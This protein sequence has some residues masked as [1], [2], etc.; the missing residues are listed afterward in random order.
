[1]KNV[2]KVAFILGVA[3][4]VVAAVAMVFGFLTDNKGFVHAGAY[5]ALFGLIFVTIYA[6][7]RPWEMSK[8]PERT[9]Q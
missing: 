6:I 8:Y 7:W 1:M 4:L 9:L 5:A 3:L 2:S